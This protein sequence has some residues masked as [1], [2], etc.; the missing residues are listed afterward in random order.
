MA[1]LRRE[2]ERI[3]GALMM[4]QGFHSGTKP[5]QSRFQALQQKASQPIESGI[6]EQLSREADELWAQHEAAI[7]SRPVS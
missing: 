1:E 2:D 4:T 7:R 3:D 6:R 5:L